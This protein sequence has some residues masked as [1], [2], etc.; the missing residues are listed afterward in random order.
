M[1]ARGDSEI[2]SQREDSVEEQVAE[3]TA[4]EA[5]TESEDAVNA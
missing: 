2:P 4:A 3:A 1:A 5:A